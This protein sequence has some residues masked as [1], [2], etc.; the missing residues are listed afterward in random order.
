[1][2]A[3]KSEGIAQLAPVVP[4]AA[5]RRDERKDVRRF[6]FTAARLDDIA[7][8]KAGEQ[9]RYYYDAEHP[10]LAVSVSATGVKTFYVI[11][12][13]GRKKE[14]FRLGRYDTGEM[15]IDGARTAARALTD[16]LA[17]G[18]RP[19]ALR[20]SVDGGK[21][22]QAAF[23]D[24][25]AN[26]RN[27]R[28]APLTEVTKHGYQIDF[29]NHLAKLAGRSMF[30]VSDDD[31]RALHAKIGKEHPTAANRVVALGSSIYGHA[32][33]A[34][35]YAGP[36]PFRGVQRF[37]EVKRERF[38]GKAELPTF[39]D[40]LAETPE[41]WRWIFSLALFTGVRRGN[42]IAARWRDFDLDAALWRIPKTKGGVAVTIPLSAEA[43]AILKQ[44][45]RIA[46]KLDY[47]F[48][49]HSEAGHVTEP[50]TAW[51][52]LLTRAKLDDLRIHDLRRTLGSWQAMTG[53]SLPVIGKSLGHATH[54]STE[55]YARLQTEPVAESV[56]TA[57]SAILAAARKGNRGGSIRKLL[58]KHNRRT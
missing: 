21:T 57:T 22:L 10:R 58:G 17:A 11:K 18:E 12:K 49:S 30:A 28:G 31:A 36:N 19:E 32:I 48:P 53:A 24:L 47:V 1:M 29:K 39:M 55:T 7:L 5:H 3:R 25:I 37:H 41:P 26:K 54:R 27:K 52:D 34:K 20:H 2:H 4:I 43:L 46:G 50:K 45:P 16:S 35:L 15:K 13:V 56:A 38:L 44:I 9:A 40:A 23:D 8:P 14:S 6:K 33:K 51:A 42:V